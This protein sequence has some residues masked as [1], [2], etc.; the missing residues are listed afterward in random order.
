[1]SRARQTSPRISACPS[2]GG[3]L[4]VLA[5]IL[6]VSLPAAAAE[7]LTWIVP[8]LERGESFL[9][10]L[11]DPAVGL[12]PEYQGARVY[13]LFHDNYLAAHALERARPDLARRIRETLAAW[14]ET[15]SGKI[16]II[17]REA[18]S[19]LPFRI[20]DLVTLDGKD[21]RTIRTERLT[22][23]EQRGWEDYAD[24]LC[25][26]ALGRER[27]DPKAAREHLERALG[28]WD[29]KG[30]ADRVVKVQ[31]IYATY[32][33]ALG[34]LAAARLGRELPQ[35]HEILERL[36][37]LQAS[38]GGWITDYAPDGAPHGLANV[39]TTCLVL[40]ALEEHARAARFFA[41]PSGLA[42]GLAGSSLAELVGKDD[43]VLRPFLTNLRSPG[44]LEVTR[45]HPP[46]PGRDPDDHADLHPG[47]WL[48]FGSLGGRDFW[49]NR[50][51]ARVV[52]DGIEGA[53]RPGVGSGAFAWRERYL[54]EEE[55]LCSAEEKVDVLAVPGGALLALETRLE[56]ARD[57][58]LGDQQEMGFGARLSTALLPSAGGVLLDSR[59]RRGEKEIWGHVAE[60]CAGFRAT[61][62]RSTGIALLAHPGNFSASRLHVRDYGL[63]LLNPFGAK[64]FGEPAERRTKLERGK[65]LTLRFAAYV[66][67]L[68]EG[69]EPTA[70]SDVYSR[71]AGA[72]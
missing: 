1:M 70:I 60:W 4:R 52:L 59:G 37:A 41:R 10:G 50:P 11:L 64:D 16:E 32:K 5:L 34:L 65:P 53:P 20:P 42:L 2:R 62:G 54:F 29:G 40:L 12:L 48:A 69:V 45:P 7:D 25:L 28:L 67:D 13:W 51:G 63:L 68:P 18:E 35:A 72:R 26:A 3:G 61:G 31:G 33:L 19:P 6:S 22:D 56:A 66:F 15:H 8:F 44:G 36:R 55:L 38:S 49:R 58:D 57:L 47:L 21:G 30:F 39:E 43:R 46:V 24:L 9:A 23:R 71:Y 14:K 27:S 17:H